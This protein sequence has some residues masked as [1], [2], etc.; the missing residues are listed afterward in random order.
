MKTPY[1]IALPTTGREIRLSP[2]VPCRAVPVLQRRPDT[3]REPEAIDRGRGSQRLEAMQFDAAPLEAAFFQ[4]V[5]RSRIGDPR[6]GDQ[7]FDIE[8]LEGEIDHRA[9]RLSGKTPAPMLD[10]QPV[11]EFRRVWMTPV[12]ADHADRHK[13]VLDQEHRFALVIRYRAHELDRMVLRIGMRQAAGVF[14]NAA[15]VG[16]M[17][18]RFYVRERRPAQHQPFGLE[19]AATRLTQCR[20]RDIL[21]HVGLLYACA[22]TQ[23]K[24]GRPVSRLPLGALQEL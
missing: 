11:A 15:V 4:D 12:D 20:G 9:R 21:Q 24:K 18:D 6:A 14:R 16:K 2:L 3:A 5:A 19:D 7:L 22:K 10:A 8:L 13:I 17:R 1:A 23:N